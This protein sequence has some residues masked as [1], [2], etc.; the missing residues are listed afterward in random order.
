MN[1]G[2]R[3]TT[4]RKQ[5]DMS[6]TDLA[7]AAGVSREIIGRYERGEALPSIEVAKKIADAFAVSLDYLVGEGINASFDKK[8]L[9]RLQDI[10][11]L[12]ADTKEKIYFVI[13]N[14]IQNVKAKKA[15]AS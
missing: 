15:F 3:I 7:K 5:K 13:D 6:Q 14:I 10:E 8:S 12:D 9:S 11:K 4:L 1:L 2:D